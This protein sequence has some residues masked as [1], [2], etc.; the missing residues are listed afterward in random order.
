MPFDGPH[1]S[2]SHTYSLVNAAGQRHWV[3]FPDP[4]SYACAMFV[5]RDRCS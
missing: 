3:T 2:G 1:G 4:E 5:K